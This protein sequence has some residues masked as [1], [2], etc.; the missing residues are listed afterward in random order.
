MAQKSDLC[1]TQALLTLPRSP[2]L[3]IIFVILSKVK[4]AGLNSKACRCYYLRI[5]IFALR[6]K[7]LR[8]SQHL[9]RNRN[10]QL[11]GKINLMVVANGM[12]VVCLY[13][14]SETAFSIFILADPVIT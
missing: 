3:F 14:K 10:R 8:V 2:G 7:V 13:S 4:S 6:A 12:A 11:Q 5:I 9:A 1:I